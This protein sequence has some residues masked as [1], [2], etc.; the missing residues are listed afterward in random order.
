LTIVVWLSVPTSVAAAG[1]DGA[2]QVLDVDLVHDPGARR[3]DLELVERA[4]APAQKLVALLVAAV[5]ELDVLLERVARAEEVDHHRVV[6]DQLGGRERVDLG[7]VAAHL[8]H[9]LAHGRQVD[10]AGYAGEVLHDHPGGG[11]LDLGVRLRGGVPVRQ[12]A[13]VVRGDVRAVL[14]A[15]EVLQQDLEAVREGLRAVDRRQP[16]DLVRVVTDLEVSLGSEAVGTGHFRLSSAIA[17]VVG[18]S[19]GSLAH[20]GRRGSGTPGLAQTVRLS[21]FGVEATPDKAGAA[22]D[23]AASPAARV[24]QFAAAMKA[25]MSPGCSA[26]RTSE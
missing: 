26:P 23:A 13:D 24:G 3:D 22:G 10:D 9:G 18:A 21:Y 25:S 16:E 4:L 14:G 1:H 7:R 15:E 20:R 6:D 12:R 11:E 19:C 2:G 17:L 5:L 8:G